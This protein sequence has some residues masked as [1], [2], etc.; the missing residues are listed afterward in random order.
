MNTPV[1]PRA[2]LWALDLPIAALRGCP[3]LT[4]GIVVLL[5]VLVVGAGVYLGFRNRLPGNL[6][7][8]A[9][10]L[11]VA[12]LLHD[13]LFLL[14][15]SRLWIATTHS[16]GGRV[17]LPL[18][19]SW[20][21][22][23]VMGIVGGIGGDSVSPAILLGLLAVACGGITALALWW[24]SRNWP[25]GSRGRIGPVLVLAL[26][27]GQPL[28]FIFYGHVEIYS[29]FAAV[30]AL[31]LASLGRDF[32][33][34]EPGVLTVF[35]FLLMVLTHFVGA[36][37][38]VPVLIMS[39]SR[40]RQT[41]RIVVP[42]L[43]LLV[44]VLGT[45]FLIPSL[46]QYTLLS[47]G[48]SSGEMVVYEADVM[49]GW[50]LLAIPALVLSFVLRKSILGDPY[51]RFL[52][53]TALTFSLLPF[54]AVFELGMYRDLDLLTPAFVAFTFLVA[55]AVARTESVSRR[56]LAGW[57]GAGA[58]LLA[59]I[60]SLSICG[61]GADTMEKHLVRA[62]MTPEGRSYGFEALAFHY[63]DTDRLPEA[64]SA[65]GNAIAIMPGNRRLWGPM[66]EIQ[67]VRGDTA[68]AVTSL[69]RSMDSPR[70]PKTAPLL[71]ELLVQTGKPHE[72]IRILEP[73]RHE[74]MLDSQAAAALAVAYYRVG[75]PE[76]TVTVGRERL[77][78]DPRDDV[79][80]FNV[81]SGLA[82]LGDFQG[83]QAA[84]R[85]AITLDPNRVDYHRALVH[86]LLRL[87]DGEAR[88]K[89]Y[90][91][92]LDPSLGQVVLKGL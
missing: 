12:W 33:R 62:T 68:N 64:E 47:R 74:L 4:A 85:S 27:F 67:L 63:L 29:L 92:G 58:V 16:F 76:S 28:S 66:G 75:L 7:L 45:A 21:G 84:L 34:R 80:H 8:G 60:L 71:A 55:Y 24:G 35:L 9:T 10:F 69:G 25:L 37:V 41:T 50:L 90:L 5:P 6:W 48:W 43:F 31:F 70:A 3:I 2:W 59:S 15:D 52:G 82:S 49:N 23:K 1:E 87:P 13:R 86:V 79:A 30:M 38:F 18:Y 91:G 36:L 19:H 88:A 22:S 42:Y 39:W 89:E 20:L 72:A 53:L 73:R 56:L 11:F 46:R 54:L 81:A 77:A 26:V 14:A 83:A 78:R 57:M 44:M 32:A 61:A 51:A 17:P 40:W 65:M